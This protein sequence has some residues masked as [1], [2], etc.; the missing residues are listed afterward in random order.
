MY[1]QEEKK[2]AQSPSSD[3]R[4]RRLFD[5]HEVAMREY[6]SRRLGVDEA[7]DAAAEVFL[8]AWR[9]ID[10][11]PTGDEARLWLYGVARNVVRNASRG[12][13]RRQ[14]LAAKT[15]GT[16]PNHGSGPEELVVRRAEDDLV[17]KAMSQLK[18]DDEELIRLHTWEELSRAELSAI[19]DVSKA[20]ID[21]RLSRARKR[22]ARALKSVG[23]APQFS[24]RPRASEEGGPS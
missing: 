23:Y 21:M 4:F 16:A 9:K 17:L 1:G 8:V 6:C 13:R 20:A 11:V 5:E 24:T 10:Q 2:L 18:P 7:N 12:S 19:L 15:A 14:R 3:T 22:L